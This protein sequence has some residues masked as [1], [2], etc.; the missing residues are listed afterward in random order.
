MADAF[1][2]KIQEHLNNNFST[3]TQIGKDNKLLSPT[4]NDLKPKSEHIPYSFAAALFFYSHNSHYSKIIWALKYKAQLQAGDYFGAMLGSKLKRGWG[5]DIDL[6]IPVPLHSKRK[7]RRGFNQ[8]EII[9]CAFTKAHGAQL[10]SDVLIRSRYTKSQTKLSVEDKI[11]NVQ[12]AFTINKKSRILSSDK[13]LH[14]VLIDDVFTSGST[15][16][17][18]YFALREHFP[19]QV[20][21][22]IA[23]LGFVGD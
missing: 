3:N 8:A 2:Y 5:K 13:I 14:I 9:A 10:G 17:A 7:R 4:D 23:T 12:D 11:K 15:L 18:C 16:T 1:N 6:V 20:R 22:S 19:P 21:I